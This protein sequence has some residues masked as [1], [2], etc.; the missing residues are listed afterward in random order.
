MHWSRGTPHF[1]VTWEFPAAAVS[2]QTSFVSVNVG[3]KDWDALTGAAQILLLL[4]RQGTK[5]I[6]Y[7]SKSMF[8]WGGFASVAAREFLLLLPSSWAI[9]ILGTI[10][11]ADTLFPPSLCTDPSSAPC[12]R[13][14]HFHNA[15]Q[16]K[17]YGLTSFFYLSGTLWSLNTHVSCSLQYVWLCTDACDVVVWHLAER[18]ALG[19][20][21]FSHST[22]SS[23]RLW[24]VFPVTLANPGRFVF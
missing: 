6:Q 17:P 3:D 18:V 2:Q 10:L 8:P 1:T 22:D 19:A 16:W 7:P 11:S 9:S 4:V 23:C 21:P 14:W 12:H 15:L 13:P 24:N 5:W 20:C